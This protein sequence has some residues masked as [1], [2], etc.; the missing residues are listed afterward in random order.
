MQIYLEDLNTL[1]LDHPIRHLEGSSKCR[2]PA[3]IDLK[4]ASYNMGHS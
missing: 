1:L 3:S 4:N 2:W